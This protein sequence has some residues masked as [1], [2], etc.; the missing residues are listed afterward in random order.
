MTDKQIKI[1]C[2]EDEVDIRSN[3][4]DILRDEGY[5][6]VEAGNGTEG[7]EVFIKER[8]DLII[9]D[10]MMPQLDGFGLLK[11]VRETTVIRQSAVPFI[12]LTALGQKDNVIKGVNLSANDYLVKPIDF[13]LLI[14][15]VKEKTSNQQ[16]VEYIHQGQISNLKNQITVALPKEVFS[17]LENITSIASKLKEEPYGPFPHRAYLDE[18]KKIYLGALNIRTAITNNLDH[19]IID[20]KLNAEEEVIN[21]AIFLEKLVDKID[22]KLS[23][24]IVLNNIHNIN[25]LPSIKIDKAVLSE[26][27]GLVIFE[28]LHLSKSSKLIISAMIDHHKQIVIIFQI[29]NELNNKLQDFN[30]AK[31]SKI[32]DKQNCRFEILENKMNTAIIIIPEYRLI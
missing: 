6:V 32:L 24:N 16:R 5:L 7:Y 11:L 1:L 26:A 23:Q 17:Y 21:L 30:I 18:I 27:I 28:L 19:K 15:K 4:A 14:A 2:V 25:L 12:F 8:P 31:I 22:K 9:S 3:I 20:F 13:D 10:I 29:Q